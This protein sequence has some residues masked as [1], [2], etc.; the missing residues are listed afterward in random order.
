MAGIER[1]SKEG[2][3]MTCPATRSSGFIS[4]L[5]VFVS[6]LS[7]FVFPFFLGFEP[8]GYQ[9]RLQNSYVSTLSQKISRPVK[10]ATEEMS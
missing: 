5:R 1:L 6:F 8:E 2:N 3:R 9:N 7:V 10:N 4:G